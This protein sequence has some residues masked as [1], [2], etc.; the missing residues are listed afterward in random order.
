M[1][2]KIKILHLEDLQSD[3]ELI[4]MELNKA[5]IRFENL[6]VD[7]KK[8]FVSALEQFTPDIILADHSLT[9]FNSMEALKIVKQGASNVP[10]LLVTAAA[11]EEFITNIMEEGAKGYILKDNLDTLPEAIKNV[12]DK[13][14]L[15]K[16]GYPFTEVILS[17]EKPYN[18]HM[19]EA[20]DD[21]EYLVEILSIFLN[22]TPRE[23]KEMTLAVASRRNSIVYG[24]AHKLKS[25]SGLLEALKFSEILEQIESTANLENS[26]IELNKLVEAAECEYL[27][28]E[29]SLQIHLKTLA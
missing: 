1:E 10:F 15:E 16:K 7:T 11:S 20:M 3:A 5:N 6:V 28:I 19:L 24:K 26:W 9:S 21:N 2:P 25:S 12:L 8:E 23:L 29:K 13:V 18:L 4:N 27:K 22:E 17:E 14:Y